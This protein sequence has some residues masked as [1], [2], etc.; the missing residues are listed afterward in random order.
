MPFAHRT[1][2]VVVALA[3]AA[4]PD[5]GSVCVAPLPKAITRGPWRALTGIVPKGYPADD[6]RPPVRTGQFRVRIDSLPA[7]A[8]RLDS[9]AQVLVQGPRS[10]HRLAVSFDGRPV[11]SFP[12][13]F[14]SH[15]STDLCLW[16]HWSY[17]SWILEPRRGRAHGCTCR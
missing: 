16:Y 7:V 12:F 17:E 14:A 8:V 10:R 13:R 1:L 11:A 4:L 3:G 9:A 15:G 5:S 2:A 6:A